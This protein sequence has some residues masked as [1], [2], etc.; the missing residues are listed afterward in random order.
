MGPGPPPE[1]RQGTRETEILFPA[2]ASR[3]GAYPGRRASESCEP[4]ICNR[5][6]TATTHRCAAHCARDGA[7]PLHLLAVREGSR[8]GRPSRRAW[9]MREV[10]PTFAC[11]S[12]VPRVLSFE[13][14]GHWATP[15][16]GLRYEDPA[17][18]LSG[19]VSRSSAAVCHLRERA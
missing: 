1:R 3:H 2:D 17:P 11:L 4:R 6:P 7:F 9:A 5:V 16:Q 13:P 14:G 12:S 8:K 19:G 10:R 18:G 15:R